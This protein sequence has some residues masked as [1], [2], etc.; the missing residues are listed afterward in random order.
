MKNETTQTTNTPM[1]DDRVLCGVI[2]REIKAVIITD[3]DEQYEN[4]QMFDWD[5]TVSF[6]GIKRLIF[7]IWNN[8]KNEFNQD[9]IKWMSPKAKGLYLE[10]I[11][12]Y[13]NRP[14]L[15]VSL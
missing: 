11:Q 6:E 2:L 5:G 1:N 12:K 10:L 14:K 7:G 3:R 15:V 8:G 9:M 13:K 4:N